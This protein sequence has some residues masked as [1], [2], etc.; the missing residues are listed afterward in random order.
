MRHNHLMP[1]VIVGVLGMAAAACEEPVRAQ[2]YDPTSPQG[3]DVDRDSDG[4]PDHQEP[5]ERDSDIREVVCD[6]DGV[7]ALT[8]SQV[9]LLLGGKP[10]R[11]SIRRKHSKQYAVVG[12]AAVLDRKIPIKQWP[13]IIF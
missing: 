4:I 8:W 11:V 7:C 2:D 13:Q 9:E 1:I 5:Q 3:T 12:S 6:G 10:G